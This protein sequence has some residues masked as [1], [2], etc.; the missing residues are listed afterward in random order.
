M[1]P[2]KTAIILFA[3]VF[4]CLICIAVALFFACTS[5]E[6]PPVE[7]FEPSKEI[8]TNQPPVIQSLEFETAHISVCDSIK[9]SCI[10]WD[11]DYDSLRFEWLSYKL[12]DTASQNPDIHE[13]DYGGKFSE[14]GSK[15]T[16]LPGPLKG[17]YLIIVTVSDPAGY[18]VSKDTTIN[19]HH[20]L[21]ENIDLV[22]DVKTI[23]GYS[24]KE[25]TKDFKIV[26]QKIVLS[27]F[28]SSNF[29]GIV[30][31]D[32][33]GSYNIQTFPQ[34]L[35]LSNTFYTDCSGFYPKGK[36]IFEKIE[37]FNDKMLGRWAVTSPAIDADFWKFEASRR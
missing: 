3:T 10:A 35:E 32:S 24:I 14:S 15:S 29:S 1:R 22:F 11:P 25:F 7:V 18:Q 12:S 26:P 21:C 16:W 17:E 20:E 4:V 13:T 23:D 27:C 33:I 6:S 2:T 9:F 19:V 30:Q 5:F 34:A 36:V 37:I 28:V 8:H 31:F